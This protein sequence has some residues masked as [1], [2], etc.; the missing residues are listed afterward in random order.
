MGFA[1]QGMEQLQQWVN[2]LKPGYVLTA[3]DGID[4][5]DELRA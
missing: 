5:I 3:I 4:G 1:P 2:L